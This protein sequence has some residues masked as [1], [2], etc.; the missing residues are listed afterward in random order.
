MGPSSVK[1]SDRL[2]IMKRYMEFGVVLANNPNVAMAFWGQDSQQSGTD[3]KRI[4]FHFIVA[5]TFFKMFQATGSQVHHAT[6]DQSWRE[7]I[8]LTALKFK[9]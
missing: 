3:R 2:N 1:D 9:P 7:G 4:K 5:K 6:A 8:S